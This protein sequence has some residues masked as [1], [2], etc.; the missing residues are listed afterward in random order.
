[1]NFKEF[2]DL[3]MVTESKIN[4]VF[5]NGTAL[6]HASIAALAAA[7]L[8]DQIKKNV[9]YGKHFK[10]DKINESVSVLAASNFHF[11]DVDSLTKDAMFIGSDLLNLS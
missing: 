4:N 2:S 5:V 11:P 6:Y 8:L 3:A 7:E 9:F 10:E 1:M